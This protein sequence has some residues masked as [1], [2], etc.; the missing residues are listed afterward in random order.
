MKSLVKD[1]GY[2]LQSKKFVKTCDQI[3]DETLD[4]MLENWCDIIFDHM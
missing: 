3:D 1:F 4:E 2:V